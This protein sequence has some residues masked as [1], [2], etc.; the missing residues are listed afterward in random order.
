MSNRQR[1]ELRRAFSSSILK[2]KRYNSYSCQSVKLEQ[3]RAQAN[4]NDKAKLN[5]EKLNIANTFIHTKTIC[6]KHKRQIDKCHGFFSHP[7][8]KISYITSAKH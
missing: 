4:K 1:E 6:M 7:S 8:S 3:M 5:N 2:F